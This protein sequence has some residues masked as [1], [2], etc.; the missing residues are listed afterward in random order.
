MTG[1][2]K[3]YV[4]IKDVLMFIHYLEKIRQQKL[5]KLKSSFKV[6]KKDTQFY[7]TSR[8]VIFLANFLKFKL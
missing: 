8:L 5:E 6:K 2:H 1:F 7:Y 4:H 3:R